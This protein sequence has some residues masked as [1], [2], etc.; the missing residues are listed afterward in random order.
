M[1]MAQT[2]AFL[3]YTRK[4]DEFFGGYITAFRKMLESAV[5]VVSG[6]ETFRVFQDIEGLIIGEDWKKKLAEVIQESSFFMPMLSP[7][8]FNSAP[9]IEE[10]KEFL[11]HEKNLGRDD[12][13]LPVYF[14]SSAKLEKEEEKS[15][16]P[17][18]M[19]LARRQMFDWRQNANVPLQD[20]AAREA[21]LRLAAQISAVIERSA[22][23]PPA[24][25]ASAPA[26]PA[27]ARPSRQEVSGDDWAAD[28]RLGLAANIR[29]EALDPRRVLWVDDWPDNNLWE[30]RA[31]ESYGVQFALAKDTSRAKELLDGEHGF[32]A[33][34][35]DMGRRGDSRA[36]VTLLKWLRKEKASDLPF[37]IYTTDRVVR[38]WPAVGQPRLQGITADPDELVD[39]VVAALR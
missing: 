32:A 36:G 11:A 21:I 8:F 31:L 1:S 23:S 28:P 9:C 13:V 16:D 12:L 10:V 3:S 2:L 37:F 33:V 27:E 14:L 4:D 30:R 15:K 20:P 35:S 29:R 25:S 5:H 34:V 7:L 39:M 17:I 26:G 24:P 6:Q 18:A 22:A 38:D 19:E